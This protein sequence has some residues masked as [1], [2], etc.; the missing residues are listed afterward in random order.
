MSDRCIVQKKINELVQNY[1]ESILPQVVREW[2]VLSSEEQGKVSRMNDLFCGLHF[3]VGLADQVEAALKVWDKLLYEHE[4]V[5]SIK[6][7]GYSKG[8]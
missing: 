6:H 7:G 1:R 2:D 4:K 5:G 3:I 8:E